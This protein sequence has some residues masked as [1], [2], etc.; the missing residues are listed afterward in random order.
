MEYFENCTHVNYALFSIN[1][2]SKCKYCKVFNEIFQ[3]HIEIKYVYMFLQCME[4][5]TYGRSSTTLYYESIYSKLRSAWHFCEN[6][7][8]GI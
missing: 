4:K 6:F 7:K 2:A 1:T 5:S 3:S 8:Y